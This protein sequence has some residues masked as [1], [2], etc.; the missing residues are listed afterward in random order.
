MRTLIRFSFY[1][2]IMIVCLGFLGPATAEEEDDNWE[3]EGPVDR[4]WSV[5]GV[6]SMAYVGTMF[7]YHEVLGGLILKEDE[8]T[9]QL[10][11]IHVKLTGDL[12]HKLS[13]TLMPEL[14]TAGRF[15]VIEANFTYAFSDKI[16]LTAGRFL[17]PFGQFNLHSLIGSFTPASRPLLYQGHE[18]RFITFDKYS[19]T[20]FLHTSRDDVGVE[21]TGSLWLGKEESMQVWYGAYVI[22]GFR[23]DS[24]SSARHWEDNNNWKGLGGK[25]VYS[26]YFDKWEFSLGGSLIWT[27]Y[28]ED[29][30]YLAYGFDGRISGWLFGR[31]RT[32]L[33]GEV[34]ISPRE[35][36]PNAQVLEGEET[37]EGF[38]VILKSELAHWLT[39]FTQF[40]R[41]S[42]EFPDPLGSDPFHETRITTD[43]ILGG[44]SFSPDRFLQVKLEYSYWMQEANLPN[45]HRMIVQALL[46]F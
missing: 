10:E 25:L 40:D 33:R 37:V 15:S 9:F 24:N 19:P 43:R 30:D 2:L 8:H 29:L 21:A 31:Y 34:V 5:S 35:I 38:Y 16:Q 4:S 23:P 44:V 26:L 41:L 3:T 32:T 28:E 14:N 6:M 18:S 42:N 13:F 27:R 45:A 39:L 1:G 36:I 20:F 46:T 17:V 22:N 12:T 11:H 7:D